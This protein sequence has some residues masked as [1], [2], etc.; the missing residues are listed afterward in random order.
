PVADRVAGPLRDEQGQPA[1]VGVRPAVGVDLVAEADP[2][3][4]GQVGAP[5]MGVELAATLAVELPGLV[6]SP[7]EDRPLGRPLAA[8]VPPSEY[9]GQTDVAGVLLH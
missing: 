3:R 1:L 7:D 2:V 5:E 6:R 8:C 4:V 9:R